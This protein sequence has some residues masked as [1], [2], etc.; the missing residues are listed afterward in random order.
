MTEALAM[1]V[2]G[3]PFVLAS[4]PL[5]PPAQQVGMTENC[6]TFSRETIGHCQPKEVGI[7]VSIIKF[8]FRYMPTGDCETIET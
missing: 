4:M 2:A 7:N 3:G 6:E 5:R 8:G 1:P